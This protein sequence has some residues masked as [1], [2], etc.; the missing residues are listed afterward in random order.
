M[1]AVNREAWDKLDLME[2]RGRAE[3]LQ[4]SLATATL[5]AGG[6]S[7][8][9]FTVEKKLGKGANAFAYLARCRPGGTL[10]AHVDM[11]V[12][13][14]VVLHLKLVGAPAE[15]LAVTE[16]QFRKTVEDETRGP[17]IPEFRSNIVHVLGQFDDDVSG[18]P[19]YTEDVDSEFVEEDPNTAIIHSSPAAI[20]TTCRRHRLRCKHAGLSGKVTHARTVLFSKESVKKLPPYIIVVDRVTTDRIRTVQATWHAHPNST[21]RFH[22]NASLTHAAQQPLVTITGVDTATAEPSAA[23]LTLVPCAMDFAWD[24]EAVVRGQRANGTAA[25]PWQG[26]YSAT[27]NGNASAPTLVF[28]GHVPETGV[29]LGWLLLPQ[30]RAPPGGVSAAS[31][32]LTASGRSGQV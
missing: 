31:M 4:K 32:T 1:A 13:L 9:D 2:I 15:V 10:G 22:R 8:A 19:D 27:Y 20:S 18:L 14:K 3:R 28:D 17:G 26:W 12:V 30:Q 16:A 7:L 21:V 6:V 5:G 23:M 29:L 25:V 11:L 24:S